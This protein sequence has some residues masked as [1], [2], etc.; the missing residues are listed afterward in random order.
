[1]VAT[2]TT[3]VLPLVLALVLHTMAATLMVA[4]L[5]AAEN[6]ACGPPSTPHWVSVASLPSLTYPILD[7]KAEHPCYF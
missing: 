4:P 6:S 5:R 3:T 1:M 7:G 2:M